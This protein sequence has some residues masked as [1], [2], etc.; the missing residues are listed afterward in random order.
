M[1][2]DVNISMLKRTGVDDLHWA[3]EGTCDGRE[4]NAATVIYKGEPIFKITGAGSI[5]DGLWSRGER[6]AVARACRYRM[7]EETG[8]VV[9]RRKTATNRRNPFKRTGRRIPGVKYHHSGLPMNSSISA[10]KRSR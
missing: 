1:S 7:L 5:A 2:C 6:A 3:A 4:F 9:P 8:Q 10:L